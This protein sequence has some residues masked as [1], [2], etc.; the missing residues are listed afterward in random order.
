M[1]YKATDN[2]FGILK[3]Q[4]KKKNISPNKTSIV[5]YN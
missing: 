5:L 1:N 3:Q 2:V 4:N